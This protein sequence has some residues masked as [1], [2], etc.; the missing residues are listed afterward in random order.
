MDKTRY[1]KQY[2]DVVEKEKTDGTKMKNTLFRMFGDKLPII[3]KD[4]ESITEKFL[5]KLCECLDF[6]D[7]EPIIRLYAYLDFNCSRAIKFV[8]TIGPCHAVCHM[9]GYDTDL[10]EMTLC[11]SYDIM[12]SLLAGNSN[13]FMDTHAIAEVKPDDESIKIYSSFKLVKHV[14]SKIV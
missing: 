4:G 14:R 8:K 13:K 7:I 12:V 9:Y 1:Y 5:M 2:L 3:L 10:F 11:I 6:E